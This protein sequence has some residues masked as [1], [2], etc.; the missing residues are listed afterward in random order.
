[1]SFV[2]PLG[3]AL[4][5]F[6][7]A[8]SVQFG[9]T[10]LLYVAGREGHMLEMFSFIHMRR[11]T[12]APAVAMQGVLTLLFIVAGNITALID[13]A[14][15]LVWFFYGLAMVAL[16]VMRRTKRNIHRPYQ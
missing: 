9:V 10:R 3:V 8:L 14:S 11:L 5:T 16:I 13:F 6:G 1:M 7:C 2:I 15:F 4:S 12:P